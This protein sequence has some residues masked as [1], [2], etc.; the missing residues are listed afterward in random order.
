M[1]VLILD[2][3]SDLERVLSN[4]LG[5]SAHVTGF[6]RAKRA[7]AALDEARPEVVLVDLDLPERSA[8]GFLARLR[9]HPDAEGTRVLLKSDKCVET[10]DL[11]R[12][13]K[14]LCVGPHF[15]RGPVSLLDLSDFLRKLAALGPAELKAGDTASVYSAASKDL[16]RSH[17]PS[18]MSE[19]SRNEGSAHERRAGRR[20]DIA[21]RA[22][23]GRNRPRARQQD[24]RSRRAAKKQ[25]SAE[26]LAKIGRLLAKDVRNLESVDAWTML[27]IPSSA[28]EELVGRAE[29]RLMRRYG[30]LVQDTAISEEARQHAGQLLTWVR[31]AADR[32]RSRAPETRAPAPLPDPP[33][34]AP[35][36]APVDDDPIAQALAAARQALSQ[37]R[38]AQA[39]G[40]LRGARNQ[41]LDNPEV[42]IWLGWA[43]YSD[44]GR[45]R[46]TRTQEALA[47]LQLGDSFDGDHPDGQL[48][49]AEVEAA[50]GNKTGA[51]ERLSTLLGRIPDHV[52]ARRLRERLSEPA[53]APVASP[54]PAPPARP[55][56]PPPRPEPEPE[57]AWGLEIEDEDSSELSDFDISA[58]D[59]SES[60]RPAAPAGG[61]DEFE[62]EDSDSHFTW[63]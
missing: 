32:L 10:D 36:P 19:S 14:R 61:L 12:H 41:S 53:P 30:D 8:L 42:L 43:M 54:E 50:T 20:R 58:L 49:L 7:L 4:L 28:S 63:S 52:Q 11:V 2:T 22:L 23:K 40:L 13:A 55:P 45:D 18:V 47:L 3:D 60:S 24:K 59:E 25:R 15:L 37:G 48:F 34:T 57:P 5:G 21:A 17:S 62:D 56:P 38:P 9:K 29:A 27:G 6:T 39:V 33:P 1:R 26:Q 31:G 35:R 16:G 46:E 51:L 44:E